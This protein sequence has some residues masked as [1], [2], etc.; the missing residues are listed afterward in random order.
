MKKILKLVI[1]LLAIVST[2]IGRTQS[3]RRDPADDKQ[4]YATYAGSTND[5][6]R[7]PQPYPS[8]PEYQPTN[9]CCSIAF[10]FCCP[11]VLKQ[12]IMYSKNNKNLKFNYIIS[13][14]NE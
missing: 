14:I 9:W 12:G 10:S 4:K 3:T 7:T 11:P 5:L 2:F 6:H 13:Q 1:L 8:Y